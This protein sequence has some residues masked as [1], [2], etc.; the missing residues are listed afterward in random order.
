MK[1]LCA[2][3]ACGLVLAMAVPSLAMTPQ[4]IVVDGVNDFDPSNLWDA[5][6]GD[7][8]TQN[9]CTSDPEDE[10]P[11]DLGDIFITNDSNFLYFGYEYDRDCFASPAVNLGIAID[12]NTAA[13]STTD[14]F[15]RKI[16]WN[17]VP[18]KPDFYIYD[19]VDGF[20]YE[21]LYSWGGAS[22]SVVTDGSNGLGIVD[23][24]GFQEMKLDLTTLGLAAGDTIHVEF[25]MTQDGTTKPPLDAACSDT[26]QTSTPTGTT[27]DI[28]GAAIEM[29]EMKAYVIQ[30]NVDVTP[31][32]VESVSAVGFS[33]DAM[34]QIGTT[35]T[36]VDVKFSEPVGTGSGSAGNYSISNTAATVTG[37]FVDGSDPSLVHLFLS[38][39]IGPSAN[40]YDVTVINVEDVAGNAILN[41]GTDNVRSFFL[42]KLRFEGN[43]SVFML[44]NSSP[45]DS[46]TVEGSL[47][48][49]TFT[50]L[51]NALMQDPGAVDSIYVTEVPLSV[52][53]NE[54][55]GKAEANLEWKFHHMIQSFEPRPNRQHLVSSD[56]GDC[57]TLAAFWND[58]NPEAVTDKEIDVIFRVDASDLSPTV[59]DTICV[60]GDQAPLTNFVLPGTM[61]LDD[62]VFPDDTA[63]DGIYAVVVRFP[64][65]TFKTVN[66]KYTFNSDFECLDQ[67]N[68]NV[69]LNDD[70]FDIVGGTNGPIDLPAR[71]INRCTVTDKAIQV[72]FRVDSDNFEFFMG[73][74]NTVGVN[75]DQLPLNFNIPSETA[76]A[77]DGLGIDAI[78]D[79]DTFSVAVVFP[80]SSN[81]N[82]EY[83][84]VINDIFECEGFGNRLIVLDDVNFSVANPMIPA[85]AIWDYCTEITTGVGDE[86]RPPVIT[87]HLSQNYPNP[88]GSRTTIQFDAKDAGN[89]K[90][91]IFDV[92]GRLVTTVLDRQVNAGLNIVQWDGVDSSNRRVSPGI[93]FY[94]LTMDGERASRR[95]VVTR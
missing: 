61:M 18:N 57:D 38:A 51:D 48:P 1:Q 28:P 72:N 25:W 43:M 50:P 90:L 5:D 71:K 60:T 20:N 21:V 68:R 85:V 54:G 89:A 11:M 59:S 47:S 39:P 9:W 77:D 81:F 83:K 33:T 4:T 16:A 23:D 36:Q 27:F 30:A 55:T 93:Y 92:A 2:L 8:Q 53:K 52:S 13:G 40:F 37:A 3:V 65:G 70:L 69:F 17:N 29:Y 67:G 41:N 7:T 76:M 31:P 73:A 49:L 63:S 22:W 66:F 6:G 14:A 32:T 34:L 64:L 87:I 15:N 56:F 26:V 82:V 42:K 58:D 62:G 88:F 78:A 12:V 80:D 86:N 24:T 44:T 19:V 74:V 91:Q 75:G 95:M 45:P 35:T 46:F 94:T 79:D 84:F 10:S